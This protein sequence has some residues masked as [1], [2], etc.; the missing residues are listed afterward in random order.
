MLWAL[1][2]SFQL[3]HKLHTH[4]SIAQC[5][6]LDV[7]FEQTLSCEN[8][9][10]RSDLDRSSLEQRKGQELNITNIYGRNIFEEAARRWTVVAAHGL[11]KGFAMQG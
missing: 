5:T 4:A 11:Y 6:T 2:C 7:H 10:N 3:L 9:W 1:Y 8:P